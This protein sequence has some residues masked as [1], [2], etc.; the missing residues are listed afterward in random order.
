MS[1]TRAHIV[2]SGLV[3]GVWYRAFTERTAGAL[4]LRGWVR[5]MP[6]G[7][8]EA[9]MEG[10]KPAIEMAVLECKKGPP[11]SRVESVEVRWEEPTGEFKSFEITH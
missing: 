5:N 11:S 9:V 6:D 1:E 10:P 2:I 8:V 7:R 4:G 3:Q